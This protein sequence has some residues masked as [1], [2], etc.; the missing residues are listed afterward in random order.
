MLVFFA[1][2]PSGC[3]TR[4]GVPEDRGGAL[5]PYGDHPEYT[6][7]PFAGF[8]PISSVDFPAA[9]IPPETGAF[10]GWSVQVAACASV[11]A[12]E[13]LQRSVESLVDEPVFIDQSGSYWKVRVG[14]YGT[15]E[16]T[17]PLR[18]RLRESGYPD[19]WSVERETTP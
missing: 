16:E 7:D 9:D 12:A 19:A 2:V 8:G 5:D 18:Q 1:A 13:T 14:A 15:A 4:T 11:Q 6:G 17:A 3:G 10:G